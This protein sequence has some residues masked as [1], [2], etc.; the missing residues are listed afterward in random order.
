MQKLTPIDNHIQIANRTI[1]PITKIDGADRFTGARDTCVERDTESLIIGNSNC[2]HGVG[3]RLDPPKALPVGN[4]CRS[5][6]FKL[7]DDNLE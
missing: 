7:E 6:E 2:S 5:I 1:L 3:L 4:F